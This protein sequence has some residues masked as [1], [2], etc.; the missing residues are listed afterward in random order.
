MAWLS[1]SCV[2]T[3]DTEVPH[4]MMQVLERR[5]FELPEPIR[6][7]S[8]PVFDRALEPIVALHVQAVRQEMAATKSLG[9]RDQLIEREA[10]RSVVRGDNCAGAHPNYRVDGNAMTNQPSEY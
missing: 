3:H 8:A 10:D 4:T 2:V 9:V 7:H 6:N 1:R 5:R